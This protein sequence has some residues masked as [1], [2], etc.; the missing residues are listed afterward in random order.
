MDGVYELIRRSGILIPRKYENTEEYVQIK[1]SLERRSRSYN[2]SNFII[3]TFY[4]ESEKFLLIPRY[5]PIKQYFHS[6]N[7][8]NLMQYG[9]DIDIQHNI[10]ARSQAQEK[11]MEYMLNHEYGILQLAPGVGKT[12]ISIHTIAE[13]KKK[14]LILVHRDPL[15]KQ[16][17]NRLL[18]FTNLQKDQI[19]RLRTPT[20]VEDLK[21]PIIIAT[22]QTFLSLLKRHREQ[23]LTE[24]HKAQVGV[25]IA[26]EV[27]TSVGAPTFSECSIHMPSRCT[28]GLS[29]TPYRYDGNGDIIQ[30]HLGDIFSDDDLE[31][32]MGARVT[33]I[34]LD[35][36]I[37]TPHRTKYVRW[38]GEFQRARYLNLMKK[39]KPFRE[40]MR[41]LLKKL[42]DERDLI[43]MAE[44]IKLIDEL[45]NET[46]SD[47]KAK[48]CGNG[49]L[50]TLNSKVTFATPGKCRD[51]VDAPWKDA[52]IMTS[53]I[54]NIEQLTGR[55][56][57]IDPGKKTP[58]VID[59][60]DFGCNEMARTF[61]GRKKFYQEKKW[62][63]RY[64]L[65]SNNGLKPVEEFE[66]TEIIGGE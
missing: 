37:D 7:M 40:A 30:F 13:R 10:K 18:T 60:V 57:R 33:V 16:W 31:G 50:D 65:F 14:T 28:Y 38:A 47:S 58:I 11:A 20:V 55:I 51:G 41:G 46:K 63:I 25:F 2:T 49:S 61:W 44:R 48:F 34:M 15:A 54:S 27:H 45:Y 29:A 64:Y 39:S 23:F 1:E 52:V 36:Q 32:T 56:I 43:C 59:M 24:L 62:P 8:K 19:A 17:R 42:K 9:Q 3:S 5:Y 12:V 21:K 26:D 22:T 4:I 53:P 66:A 35:Y 6:Y